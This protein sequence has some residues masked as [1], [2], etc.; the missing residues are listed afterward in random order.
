MNEH[1]NHPQNLFYKE[2]AWRIFVQAG[3]PFLDTSNIEEGPI[4]RQIE[5]RKKKSG[6][7]FYQKRFSNFEFF[8]LSKITSLSWEKF[9][10]RKLSQRLRCLKIFYD[11][12]FFIL[13]SKFSSKMFFSTHFGS[14][15][16]ELSNVE[17]GR[18]ADRIMCS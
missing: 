14:K 6:K 7:Y 16:D 13:S 9:L 15:F 5:F 1:F 10:R 3:G 12:H 17:M 8:R 2:A 18:I 11:G 4:L